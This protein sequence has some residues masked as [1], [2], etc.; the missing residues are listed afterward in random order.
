L[1]RVRDNVQEVLKELDRLREEEAEAQGKL[2]KTKTA[3]A[4][5][6]NA[7]EGTMLALQQ[8][9]SQTGGVDALLSSYR[10]QLTS[11]LAEKKDAEERRAK[12]KQD[13]SKRQRDL[14]K[15]HLATE[16]HFVPLF[17]DLAQH[18]LGMPL[19]IKMTASEL[20]GVGLLLEVRGTARRELHQLS[21]SQRFFLDIALRM[22]L[23]QFV[24]APD[25]PGGL[26]IDTPEGS[27]DIAYEK[28]AGEMLAKFAAARHS[29]LMTANL[30]SS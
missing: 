12:L 26:Y 19:E 1:S 29:I 14:Q 18:F 6:D 22:A 30:N 3:L 8:S 25:A 9:L 13:L 2:T 28:R 23:T 17:T 24:S 11:L 20:V 5:F 27:L 16:K 4:A 15:Q 7:N 21:E 10:A